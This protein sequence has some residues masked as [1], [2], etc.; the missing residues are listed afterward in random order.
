MTPFQ[1]W[2]ETNYP[3]LNA[4][5]LADRLYTHHGLKVSPRT[6]RSWI[7][8]ERDPFASNARHKAAL[9]RIINQTGK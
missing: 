5:Q 6:V 3:A 4:V 1:Q 7:S 8:K 2:R 9:R